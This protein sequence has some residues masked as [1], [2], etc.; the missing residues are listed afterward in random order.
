VQISL[1]EGSRLYSNWRPGSQDSAG[2]AEAELATRSF[3][4]A[5]EQPSWHVIPRNRAG[6]GI[7]HGL[8]KQSRARFL[9]PLGMTSERV[10]PQPIVARSF[11]GTETREPC[12]RHLVIPVDLPSG[13]GV[14]V[15]FALP[16]GLSRVLRSIWLH[17]A[18]RNRFF[19]DISKSHVLCFQ[20]LLSFVPTVLYSS[21]LPPSH[22]RGKSPLF[23]AVGPQSAINQDKSSARRQPL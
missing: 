7:E 19:C 6:R 20:V 4:Q 8:E 15:R 13:S 1:R 3:R 21:R 2:K 10:L 5:A 12:S 23:F 14:L 9:A 22:F 18:C 16:E 11:R 17:L